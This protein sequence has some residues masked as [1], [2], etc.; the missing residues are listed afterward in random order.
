MQQEELIVIVLITALLFI[1]FFSPMKNNNGTKE[2][3]ESVYN[4]DGIR[5]VKPDGVIVGGYVP[6]IIRPFDSVYSHK[7]DSG[8][9]WPCYSALKYQK[10]CSEQNAIDY[11]AMRPIMDSKEYLQNIEKM[12]NEKVETIK[13]AKAKEAVIKLVAAARAKILNFI[14]TLLEK[15]FEKRY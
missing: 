9:K 13:A 14:C 4:S 7:C 2:S 3:F 8:C 12:F 1:C 5:L 11:F 10:W 6:Q 15:L